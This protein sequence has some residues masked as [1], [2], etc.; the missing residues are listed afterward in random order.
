[1]F[2]AIAL[3]ILGSGTSGGARSVAMLIAGRTIQGLGSG[4]LYVLSDIIICDLIPPR[5]R[6][7]YISAVLSTAAIGITIGPI[8]RRTRRSKLAL[9][10]LNQP[11][12]GKP[13]LNRDRL[14]SQRTISKKP[15]LASCTSPR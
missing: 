6:G 3:F 14:F 15:N 12:S 8:W 13:R 2:V 11:A 4:G 7:P 1:M 10:I 5:Y 9:G